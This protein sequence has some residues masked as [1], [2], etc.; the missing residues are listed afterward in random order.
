MVAVPEAMEPRLVLPVTA[1][2][3]PVALPKRRLEIEAVIADRRLENKLVEVALVSVAFVPV[4]LVVARLVVVALLKIGLEVKE[5][6]TLPR[7]SVA[8]VRLALVLEAKNLSRLETEVVATTPL[9]VEVIT[10]EEAVRVLELMNLAVV[11]EI[12]PLV[13]EVSVKLLV[14]VETERVLLVMIEEVA[15]LPATLVVRVLPTA[16]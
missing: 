13:L 8:T 16:V 3:I 12:T 6:V 15:I 2:L 14:L 1:R 11:V 4:R 7:V 5:Y 10:P 9:T